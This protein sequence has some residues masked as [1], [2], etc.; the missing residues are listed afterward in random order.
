MDSPNAERDFNDAYIARVKALREGRGLTAAQ[1]A[2]LLGVPADRYR[3]YELRSPLPA[4]LVE[5]FALICGQTVEY[6]LLG[7][8][9]LRKI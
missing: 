5:R 7:K 8:H 9:G 2:D 4:Y 6:V 1:M 3:K